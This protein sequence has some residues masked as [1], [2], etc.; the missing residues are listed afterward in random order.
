MPK[1][2]ED[3]P[4]SRGKL[5]KEPRPGRIAASYGKRK[6]RLVFAKQKSLTSPKPLRADGVPCTWLR[7][8]E[9]MENERGSRRVC[10]PRNSPTRPCPSRAPFP[11]FLKPLEIA[12]GVS[13]FSRKPRKVRVPR[14]SSSS[15]KLAFE[16]V[17][18]PPSGKMIKFRS[19]LY[20]H[21]GFS[22]LTPFF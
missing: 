9:D 7:R 18:L 22:G 17:I 11:L 4:S 1:L 21:I 16:S 14:F 2:V 15:R 3:L 20:T 12:P 8:S 6:D 5:G 13:L 19:L 10:F